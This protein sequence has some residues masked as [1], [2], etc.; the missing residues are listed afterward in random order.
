MELI[1]ATKMIAGYTMGMRP[2]GRESIVVVVKGTFSIPPPGEEPQLAEEQVPLVMAD[3]F[4][5]E[6]GFSAPL[7]ESEFALRKPKCDVLLNGSAFAPGGKPAERVT[8]S[9]RVGTMKK[10]FDVVGNRVW[11]RG[12]LGPT[13]SSPEPFVSMPFSYDKAFGGIDKT[14]PEPSRWRTFVPNHFG[15]GYHDH[16]LD[17]SINSK[18]L[19]NTEETGRHVNDSRG[20]Y[21]PMSFGPIFRAWQPRLKYAGT[22]DD[23]WLEKVFPF[24]PADF[25]ERYFQ[26]APEDQQIDY[27]QGG[28]EVELVNLTPE[29]RTRIRLPHVR[30]PVEFIRNDYKSTTVDALADTLFLEADKGRFVITWRAS[31]PLRKNVFEVPTG[32]VGRMPRG[33]Y[34]ARESGKRYYRNLGALAQA[35]LLT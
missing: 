3:V 20:P 11:R 29:G 17:P 8:V 27:L 9:L 12:I 31:T 23:K 18:P 22:Y 19:P 14:N 13:A 2:D 25:D 15:V 5:G 21:R 28:E 1:N 35:T 33:W 32:I 24:L 34:R 10:S 6:P 4:T 30:V 16:P 7:Y 26:A